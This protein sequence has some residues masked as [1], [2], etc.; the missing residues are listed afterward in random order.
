MKLLLGISICCLLAGGAMAQRGGGGH[1][2]GGGFHGGGS[3]GGGGFRGGGSMG[4]GFRGGNFGGGSFGGGSFGGFRGGFNGNFGGFR[5]GFH[6]GFGGFRG[7]F[8]GFGWGVGF[9]YWPGY[10]GFY[11]YPYDYGY[12]YG[13]YGYGGYADPYAYSYA[14]TTTLVYPPSQP[15]ASAS[16]Y[17]EPP[18]H[19]SVHVYD[20]Y[21]Q[22]VR[23]SGS[24]SGNSSPLYLIALRDQN[25]IHAALS[26]HVEG[27]TLIYMTMQHEEK[28]VPLSSV[29]R[30]LT[31]QLN[32][33]RHVAMNL[34]Q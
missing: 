28:R 20:E 29:D 3:M 2:G 26:Y 32:H 15:A 22:E 25:T 30:S 33:E 23:G 11:D 21:G 6:N 31:M 14:P 1:G 27:N 34:P 13:G 24:P 17:V 5:G 10:G 4:G 19:S 8:P 12:P 9:G 16:V 7:S 18:V